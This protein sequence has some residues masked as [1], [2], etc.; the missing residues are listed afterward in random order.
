ML[1][2]SKKQFPPN[3]YKA[4]DLNRHLTKQH[5]LILNK[6][7]EGCSTSLIFIKMQVK[8]IIGYNCT[9][10]IMAKSKT[11]P[12]LEILTA[13]KDYKKL[14]LSYISRREAKTVQTPWNTVGFF[15]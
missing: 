4:R 3:I 6:H 14:E 13:L 1:T 11:K 15:F 2:H 12:N 10:I 7:M 9:Y 8:S 5:N